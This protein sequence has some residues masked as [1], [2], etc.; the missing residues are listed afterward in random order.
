MRCPPRA[1]AT[2]PGPRGA[3]REGPRGTGGEGGSKG[4]A[5]GGQGC[6]S[7]PGPP[8]PRRWKTAVENSGSP[9]INNNNSK[10]NDNDNGD[11]AFP[12]V[13]TSEINVLP[14]PPPLASLG[15]GLEELPA[16]RGPGSVWERSLSG[17]SKT[18]RC[19]S[20]V[21]FSPR[22]AAIVPGQG[23]RQGLGA[24]AKGEVCGSVPRPQPSPPSSS[25]PPPLPSCC[26]RRAC[27][28]TG[29]VRGAGCRGRGKLISSRFLIIP[30]SAYKGKKIRHPAHVLA[31]S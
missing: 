29:C 6:T 22:D 26:Y 12:S 19:G 20:C 2:V 9:G 13:K 30:L 24:A 10:G 4:A 8:P 17:K 16:R 21:P 25:P 23:P 3:L 5:S 7:R 15:P 11:N 14:Q 27:G 28:G 1:A 31:T 18:W